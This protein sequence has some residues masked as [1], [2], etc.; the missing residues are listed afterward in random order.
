MKLSLEIKPCKTFEELK[1]TIRDYKQSL[2]PE[3]CAIYKMHL[4]K[5]LILE[6]IALNTGWS[7]TL[8]FER[9]F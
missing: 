2:T 1:L 9:I 4:R 7:N 3:K 8:I 5:R 6:V